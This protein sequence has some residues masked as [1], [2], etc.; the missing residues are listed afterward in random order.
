LQKI[1]NPGQTVPFKKEKAVQPGPERQI[2]I[3][4]ELKRLH[5]FKYN[6]AFPHS[7]AIYGSQ[8][9]T[10]GPYPHDYTRCN[11]IYILDGTIITASTRSRQPKTANVK[12]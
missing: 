10:Y 11:Y 7:P 1:K 3:E 6:A 4:A 8:V 9:E 5:R 2:Q 12:V